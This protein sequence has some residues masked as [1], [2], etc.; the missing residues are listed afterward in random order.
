MSVALRSSA[1][2]QAT[3]DDRFNPR[4]ALGLTLDGTQHRPPARQPHSRPPARQPHSLFAGSVQSLLKPGAHTPS[5][6]IA[7]GIMWPRLISRPQL[8]A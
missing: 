1:S 3:L 7:L 2:D 4:D 6:L 5:M 8:G